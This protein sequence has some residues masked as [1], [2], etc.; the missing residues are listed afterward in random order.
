[1]AGGFLDSAADGCILSLPRST[2][3]LQ[4]LSLLD[5]LELLM[6]TRA[7]GD[8][9][10]CTACAACWDRNDIFFSAC[11]QWWV[12]RLTD[13]P[14]AQLLKGLHTLGFSDRG[15]GL[16]S[17]GWR[18][19]SSYRGACLHC[20]TCTHYIV[21]LHNLPPFTLLS[22]GFRVSVTNYAIQ[23]GCIDVLIQSYQ[24]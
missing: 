12:V 11:V 7:D 21:K 10:M 3:L 18:M 13:K 4:H 9:W 16:H 1:M 24:G 6:A 2:H 8:C 17:R 15:T 5:N 14:T 22:V 19:C 23:S 20:G